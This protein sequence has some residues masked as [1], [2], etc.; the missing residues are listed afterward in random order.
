MKYLLDMNAV[1][2]ILQ[3]KG[4]F[5]M[6]EEDSIILSFITIIELLAFAKEQEKEIVKQFLN[7]CETIF[8]ENAWLENVIGIRQKLRLKI[9]DAI[10]A[11]SA[12]KEQA[13]LVTADKEMIKKV[14]RIGMDVIN[15]LD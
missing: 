7:Y 15:P 14:K 11:A 1:L 3:G 13:I 6:L 4:N 10:I 9:P 12:K 5:D 2:Y 8:I